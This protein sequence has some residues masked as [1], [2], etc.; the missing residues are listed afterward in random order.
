MTAAA[1]R[2]F[3]LH[4][5]SR[6]VPVALAMIA[7]IGIAL[8]VTLI[9]HW[10]AYG[11]LQ[12]PLVFEAACAAVIAVTTGS[13]LGEPER[14]TGPWLPPLRLITTLALT[15][16]AAAVLIAAG[17]G[18]TLAGGSGEVLRNLAGL[19]GL[20]LL[21]AVLLGGGLAWIAPLGYLLASVY[22]L[23]T[24]WHGPAL[25]T[26]WLWPARPP[27]DLGGAVCATLAFAAGLTLCTIR[28]A[29]DRSEE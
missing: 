12:L 26:A 15:A 22:A 29:H 21:C 6:R 24:L 27:G 2:T 4:A 13:P 3:R 9:G 14:V 7:V 16:V 10:D 23:Y 20:G 25:T 19:T 11:A 8:R 17:L 28:G 5:A 18:A 1:L